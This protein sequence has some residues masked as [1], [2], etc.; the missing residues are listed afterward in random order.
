MFWIIA[1][2][3][4][5]WLR[6]MWICIHEAELRTTLTPVNRSNNEHTQMNTFPN[7]ISFTVSRMHHLPV[8]LKMNPQNTRNIILKITLVPPH[9][10][11]LTVKP[12]LRWK[13]VAAEHRREVPLCD[14]VPT[15][16]EAFAIEITHFSHANAH[17]YSIISPTTSVWLHVAA[18]WFPIQN[19]RMNTETA[20]C[21]HPLCRGECRKKVP[22]RVRLID[23]A[24]IVGITVL[25]RIILFYFCTTQDDR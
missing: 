1:K 10:H 12:L 2:N 8:V 5:R 15:V 19:I 13:I 21:W 3:P 4:M 7:L 23:F 20:Y 17:S 16:W 22:Q 25:T 24:V 9:T 18:Q 11:T 14:F 6:P